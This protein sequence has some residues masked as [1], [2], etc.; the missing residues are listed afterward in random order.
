MAREAVKHAG[1]VK[2]GWITPGMERFAKESRKP[3]MEHVA[4]FIEDLKSRHLDA[5]HIRTTKT[6]LT[7]IVDVGKF[8]TISDLT[9]SR[10]RIA[11]NNIVGD[12]LSIHTMNAHVVAVKAFSK[13]LHEDLKTEQYTLSSLKR[14]D[15]ARDRRIQRRNLSVDE[16]RTLIQETANAPVWD[17]RCRPKHLLCTRCIDWFKTIGTSVDMSRAVQAGCTCPL[18]GRSGRVCEEPKASR[19]AIANGTSFASQGMAC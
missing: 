6:Y 14:Q 11:I 8:T 13:W 18:R 2:E 15:E 5:K 7:R 10:V 19:T 1:R 17:L 9:P 4:E 16:L 12:D 3:I